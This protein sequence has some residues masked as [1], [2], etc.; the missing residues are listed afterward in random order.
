MKRSTVTL[1]LVACAVVTT[2]AAAEPGAD[3]NQAF[4]VSGIVL[5]FTGGS[6]SGMPMITV[7]DAG[8]GQIDVALGP[9]WYLQ[10]SGFSVSEGDSV[11]LLA[12][13]CST[14]AAA[15]VAAWVDNLTNTTAVDLRDDDGRPL[16][17]TRQYQRGGSARPGQ[18]GGSL[19]SGNGE[20]PG[21]PGGSGTGGGSG[22]AGGSGTPG[23]SGNGTGS[24]P[25]NGSG[26][27]MSQVETGSGIV[28]SFTGHAGSGEPLLVLD[29][30]GESVEITVS[31][32]QPIAAA[33]LLIE[34]GTS[35]TVTFAPTLCDD[36][37][38]LV[39]ISIIDD[40]TG[41]LI[42]LRDPET[43]FPMT[44]G[45]GHNRPNWP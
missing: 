17:V 1:T 31:P 39:A 35:L 29:V 8:V 4:E 16:W 5:A 9:V 42:Q 34:E 7:D 21:E 3:P 45:G 19:G 27:D 20:P 6:G 36:E 10:T 44:N 18:A 23:G 12:Y 30:D 26:L 22:S 32:Y 41:V 11:N 38:H 25:A 15:A 43:G 40:A 2:M 14:C 28:A 24:G 37:P 13:Q 33:G